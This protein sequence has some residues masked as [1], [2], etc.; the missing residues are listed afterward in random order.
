MHI[1]LQKLQ[2]LLEAASK[3][4]LSTEKLVRVSLLRSS[5]QRATADSEQPQPAGMSPINE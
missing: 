2:Q 5:Y 3:P 4:A 1:A